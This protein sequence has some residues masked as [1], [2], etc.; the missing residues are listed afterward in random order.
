MLNRIRRDNSALHSH[1]GLTLLSSSNPNV[2]FFEKAAPGRHNVLLVGICLNP[3][4]IEESTVE[5]PLWQFGKDDGGTLDLEDLV[6]GRR[7]L[8]TGKW[9]T[10]R[11]DPWHLPFAIWRVRTGEI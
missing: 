9:Q 7:F 5:I 2:M 1:L 8:L 4:G 11:L 10:L 6:S 3:H